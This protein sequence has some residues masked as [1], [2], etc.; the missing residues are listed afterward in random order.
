MFVRLVED[1][2]AIASMSLFLIMLGMWTLFL[3]GA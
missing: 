1:L 2:A 3:T